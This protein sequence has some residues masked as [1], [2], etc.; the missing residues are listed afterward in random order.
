MEIK[1]T[2]WEDY[3]K[4]TFLPYYERTIKLDVESFGKEKFGD[5]YIGLYAHAKTL[6]KIYLNNTIILLQHKRFK[7]YFLKMNDQKV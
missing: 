4:D 5:I 1:Y 3:Y 7:H 2:H 6:M